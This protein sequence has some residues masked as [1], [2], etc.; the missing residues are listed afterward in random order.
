MRSDSGIASVADLKGKIV[1]TNAAGSAV[2]IA[3]KAMLRKA[4]LED[5]RDFTVIEASFPAMKAMLAEKKVDMI[6]SV[7]PF[8]EDPA[9]RSSSRVLFTQKDALGA[10]SLGLWVVRKSFIEKNRAALVDFLEDTLVETRWYLDPAHHEE[11]VRIAATFTKAPPSLFD[12]WLFTKKDYYR[13]PNLMPNLDALQSNV[14][15]MR[16]L[17]FISGPLDVKRYIDLSMVQEAAKRL[18]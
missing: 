13:D 1:G 18:P 14:D 9:L 4:K 3:A 5:R 8:S 15:L 17:G 7:V 6:P 11:A 2:D 16:S 12:G 10:S